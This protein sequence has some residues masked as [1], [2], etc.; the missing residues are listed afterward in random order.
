M[1][2]ENKVIMFCHEQVGSNGGPC[3]FV[4]ALTGISTSF[5]Q[6]GEQIEI[7]SG[8]GS[9]DSRPEPEIF[10]YGK[11]VRLT[12]NAIAVCKFKA[13]K[14]PGKYYVPVKI[15]YT[16]QNGRRQSIQKEIEYTVANIQ[17]Q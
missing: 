8:V 4:S 11:P 1:I 17:E 6:P 7:F 3:T 10:V 2:I 14:R 15:N 9:F 12:E 16:D 5:V 13:E